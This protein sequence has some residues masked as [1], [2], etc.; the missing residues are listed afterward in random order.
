[1]GRLRDMHD[2]HE[3]DRRVGHRRVYDRDLLF[4][5]LREAGLTV[6]HWEGIMLKPLSNAQ[7]M[8]WSEELIRA[9]QQAG[10]ELPD[11][12][13]EIYVWCTR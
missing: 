4:Q 8:T 7:M 11:Y 2:L 9:F 1:M 5:Q 6:Q 13:G 10:R 3:G 12:C